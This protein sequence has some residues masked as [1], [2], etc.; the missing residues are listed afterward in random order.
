MIIAIILGT[1]FSISYILYY[2]T[3][4]DSYYD[5]NKKET[6]AIIKNIDCFDKNSCYADIEYTINNN[7]YENNI[8]IPN[9]LK[10]RW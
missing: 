9:N 7:K 4:I 5:K 10:N 6:T 3:T 2:K 8:N 1:Y